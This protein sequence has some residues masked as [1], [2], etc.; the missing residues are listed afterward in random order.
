MADDVSL[1]E[2]I[3]DAL[4]EDTDVDSMIAGGLPAL[5]RRTDLDEKTYKLCQALI[6][7][8]EERARIE[9]RGVVVTADVLR[10][11]VRRDIEM[12]FNIERLEA[13]YLLTQV[14]EQTIESPD[15]LLADFPH[16]QRSV[17]NYGVPSFAG[18]KGADYDKDALARDLTEVLRTF[19][20][21]LKRETV[22]V[23]VA[24]T[25]KTGM[26][27]TVDALLMLSP[28]PERLRLATT[29]DLD[30]G[31]ALTVAEEV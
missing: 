4:G 3:L 27:V 11:A 20:P 24:Y 16:V 26:K 22:K 28:V 14:E 2:A 12:L 7:K 18:R 25:E 15:D 17:L 13:R 30:N 10:E 5:R 9:A 29:I 8:T 31:R 1:R 21:R 23:S 6:L 19:E